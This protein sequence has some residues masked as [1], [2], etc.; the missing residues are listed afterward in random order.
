[1]PMIAD[2]LD[3]LVQLGIRGE[4]RRVTG[5]ARIAGVTADNR[6]KTDPLWIF[7]ENCSPASP[8]WIRSD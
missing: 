1:V 3:L 5:I 6:V 7:D 4:S 8:D 2:A